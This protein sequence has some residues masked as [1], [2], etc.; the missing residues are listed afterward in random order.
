L[1]DCCALIVEGDEASPIGYRGAQS[2]PAILRSTM[3]DR[4]YRGGKFLGD[5]QQ[6]NPM[7]D[8]RFVSRDQ[9]AIISELATRVK[10]HMQVLQL[11]KDTPQSPKA[12]RR[13]GL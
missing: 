8:N 13:P 1:L 4:G 5:G 9:E 7:S 12:H 11:Q 3:K 6:V 2:W 10:S